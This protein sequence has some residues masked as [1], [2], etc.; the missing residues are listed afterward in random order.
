METRLEANSPLTRLF[1]HAHSVPSRSG[2]IERG[3]RNVVPPLAAN[4]PPPSGMELLQNYSSQRAAGRSAG[5]VDVVHRLSCT[6]ACGIF[7][8]QGSNPCPLHGQADSLPL[9]HQ[10]SFILKGEGVWLVVA[11]FLVQES[12]CSYPGRSDHNVPINLQ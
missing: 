8:D 11:N 6:M 10:T 4:S 9:S 7:P 12:F 5:R 1:L 3:E 2:P